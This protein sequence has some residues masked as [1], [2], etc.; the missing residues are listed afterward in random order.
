M[1]C[2]P[3]TLLEEAKCLNCVPEG[4][5][6]LVAIY[7]A[8]QIAGVAADPDQLMADAVCLQ[9][10]PESARWQVILYLACQIASA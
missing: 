4:D 7:L 6:L 10:I 8:A 5:Q 3:N 1:S 9:C 2:D